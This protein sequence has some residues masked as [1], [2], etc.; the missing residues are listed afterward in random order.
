MDIMVTNPGVPAVT[1]ELSISTRL[2]EGKILCIDFDGTCV[3]HEYPRVGRFIGA[4]AV[5][6]EFVQQGAKLILWTMRSGKELEDA[7]TWFSDRHLPLF[8]VNENPDQK[9]WTLSQKAYAHLYIDDAA[10][11]A[12]LCPGLLGE[13]PYMNWA[14]VRQLVLGGHDD[15]QPKPQ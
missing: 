13:R 10:L 2:L 14:A 4:E 8:G 1:D 9:S 11:G 3:T 6:L 12:P 7:K 15:L 5:L